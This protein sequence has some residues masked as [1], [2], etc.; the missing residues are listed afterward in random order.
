MGLKSL[1][2]YFLM[3][4]EEEYKIHQQLA[5]QRVIAPIDLKHEESKLMARRLPYSQMAASVINNTALK[6]SKQKEILE[7]DNAVAE[8]R[9]RF[10]QTLNTLQSA[11]DE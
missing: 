11:A 10:L 3:L 7:L 8:Q 2:G 1:L 4:A 5:R 6:R 9:D